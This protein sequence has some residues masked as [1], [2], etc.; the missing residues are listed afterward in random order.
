MDGFVAA[1]RDEGHD[2]LA[3][4]PSQHKNKFAA[5]RTKFHGPAGTYR[6]TLSTIA[7]ND[8]ESTYR[9]A[10][11]GKRVGSF[12]NPK[13][14]SSYEPKEA[15]WEGIPFAPGDAIQ[16]EFN[17]ATNEADGWSRGRWTKLRFEPM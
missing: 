8:G 13:V 11:N 15:S 17:T 9:L 10:V 16:V 2:A 6:V 12:T 3:I 14:K 1:Y 7:E 4:N 5:A